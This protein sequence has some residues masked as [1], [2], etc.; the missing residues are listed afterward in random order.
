MKKFSKLLSLLLTVFI[1]AACFAGCNDKTDDNDGGDADT[2]AP[3]VDYV[4]QLKLDMSTDSLKL[5]DVEIKQFI[6]G[7]TTHF[8]VPTSVCEDGVLKARYLAIN[9]PESTGKI[10]EWGKKASNFTR[11]KLE[12]AVS[13]ILES[14][15][16]SWNID[17]TGDRH[18]VWIWYKTAEDAEYR[19]LNLEILQEGLAV[20][21][22]SSQNRY[23]STCM[24][25][26]NQA[27]AYKLNVYSGE[28]DPD[29]YYGDCIELTLKELR[30]NP[31]P[32][33]NKKVAFTGVIT[34]NDNNSVYV[35]QF[36][37]ET[38]MYHGI[39][40]YY[41][42]SFNGMSVLRVGNLVRVVGSMQYYEAGGTYQ[43]SG[44][45]YD[46]MDPTNPN[47]IQKLGTAEPPFTETSADL[48]A[49]GKVT[50]TMIENDEEKLVE[51]DYAELAL[52]TSISMKGLKVVRVSTQDDGASEGAMTVTCKV[53]DV[54]VDVRTNVL[55]DADGNLVTEDYFLGKTMDVKG[56]VDV[57][58]GGYQI[59]V[60]SVKDITLH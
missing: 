29:F 37:D 5:V 53:G 33:L 49:N 17:S 38:N 40:V 23:G 18:L 10:E 45:E 44:L 4:S 56:I 32:Y 59:K 31:E 30:T 50:V 14:D 15:D 21:S 52:S 12:S 6:D 34:K 13:I 3:F 41:G 28:K 55:L 58:K 8:Y 1:V 7:D 16:G 27:K 22:S 11:S 36:D 48:F 39:S 24:S 26:I 42:F 35:E 47:N 57:F 2:P 20:A 51:F 60:F 46:M 54:T 9:T 19:N 43:I 25:A